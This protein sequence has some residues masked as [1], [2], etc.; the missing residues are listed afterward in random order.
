MCSCCARELHEM[1]T[2]VPKELKVI[3]AQVKV[4]KQVL[5]VYSYRHCEQ[6][7][8]KTPIQTAKMPESVFPGASF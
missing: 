3:H 7:E 5:Y 2:Q 8:I 6:H 4:L 1:S